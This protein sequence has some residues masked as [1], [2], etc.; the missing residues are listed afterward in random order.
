MKF[1]YSHAFLAYFLVNFFHQ[2]PFFT[3]IEVN[4]KSHP[5]EHIP[6]AKQTNIQHD[7]QNFDPFT[8]PTN[9]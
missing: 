8:I 7:D 6:Q 9:V 5:F 3:L 2:A 1:L 4:Y